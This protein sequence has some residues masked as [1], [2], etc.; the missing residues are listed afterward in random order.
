MMRTISAVILSVT[1]VGCV[2]SNKR[3]DI[4]RVKNPRIIERNL[5]RQP[6]R[7]ALLEPK[8]PP[9]AVRKNSAKERTTTKRKKK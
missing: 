7:I 2:S 1:I 8:T 5:L 6:E 3:Q 9:V 4:V